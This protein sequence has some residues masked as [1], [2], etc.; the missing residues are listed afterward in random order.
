MSIPAR[1]APAAPAATAVALAH[2][3]ATP[4]L[5][6]TPFA[7][8]ATSSAAVP[9]LAATPAMAF[10]PFATMPPK[11]PTTCTPRS[12]TRFLK[13]WAQTATKKANAPK[14]TRRSR[15]LDRSRVVMSD[16]DVFMSEERVE[17]WF[18]VSCMV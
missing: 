1:I 13:M 2:S 18:E 11:A 3:S 12:M 8:C 15:M 4:C 9:L 14:R 16:L 10:P 6:T 5:I 7:S 17:Y